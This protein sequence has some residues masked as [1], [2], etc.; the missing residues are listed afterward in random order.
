MISISSGCMQFRSPQ[1]ERNYAS[2]AALLI[3]IDPSKMIPIAVITDQ[4][5]ALERYGVIRGISARPPLCETMIIAIDGILVRFPFSTSQFW[6]DDDIGT[7][8]AEVTSGTHVI[9]VERRIPNVQNVK[10]R[11]DVLTLCEARSD[12]V[13][14]EHNKVYL[15][16][17]DII[18]YDQ[19]RETG[20][21][22][23]YETNFSTTGLRIEML[24]HTYD[25][26]TGIATHPTD[27]GL[28][29]EVFKIK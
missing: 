9:T 21:L 25:S 6:K 1:L 2:D 29:F 14:I 12:T 7:N 28:S 13:N 17:T 18:T 10:H 26:T 27:R 11:D 23:I 3:T 19:I 15:L 22:S 20:R 5:T 16:S 4:K 24:P 8:W